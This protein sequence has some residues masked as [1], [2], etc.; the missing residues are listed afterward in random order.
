MG[1]AGDTVTAYVWAPIGYSAFGTYESNR[2]ADGPFIY[3]GFRPAWVMVKKIDSAPNGW[4]TIMDSTRSQVNPCNQALYA[5]E[6]QG[7][8]TNPEM[9]FLSNGFKMR[10][11][12]DNLNS[13]FGGEYVYAC[14]AENPFG[15]NNVAPVTAR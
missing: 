15:G 3:T 10:V 12:F 11:N 6:T 1:A 2:D 8:D 13:S 5:N 7:N 9:D 4:W 14:F